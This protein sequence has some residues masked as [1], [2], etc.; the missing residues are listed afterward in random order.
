MNKD[1][2]NHEKCEFKR[3]TTILNLDENWYCNVIPNIH[4]LNLFPIILIIIMIF[5][6]RQRLSQKTEICD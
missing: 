1:E 6:H 2:K 3:K 5:V 4:N